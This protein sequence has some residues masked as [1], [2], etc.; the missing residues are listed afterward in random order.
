MGLEDSYQS[1]FA[2]LD[3]LRSAL[4]E[5][6]M[7][8][9]F[10]VPAG[11]NKALAVGMAGAT[12]DTR[13][14]VDAAVR[15][16]MEGRA[17]AGPVLDLPRARWELNTCHVAM[18]TAF[19]SFGSHLYSLDILG[20]LAGFA[21]R[22][23]EWRGWSDTVGRALETCQARFIA[24]IGRALAAWVDLAERSS[25]AAISVQAVGQQFNP[26]AQPLRQELRAI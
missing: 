7:H 19:N 1:L 26:A 5:L 9:D 15:A 12:V 16:A 13:G 25:I 3:A 22:G 4:E 17:A 18:L 23:Q 8:L 6:Q 21:R 20:Q 24:A 11:A 14:Y 10:D 2:E